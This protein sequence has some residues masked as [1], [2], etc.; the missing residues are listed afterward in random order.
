[1]FGRMKDYILNIIDDHEGIIM[2]LMVIGIVI[3]SCGLVFGGYCLT[4]WILM[5]F[6]NAIRPTFDLPK[7]S[8]WVFVGAAFVISLLTPKCKK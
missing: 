2:V 1:M 6:Y 8:Y 4:G 7:L 5:V 3:L